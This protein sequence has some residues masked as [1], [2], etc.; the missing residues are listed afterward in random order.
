MLDLQYANLTHE[1][2]F[3]IL[4]ID[5]GPEAMNGIRSGL[6]ASETVGF[7]KINLFV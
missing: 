4:P 7:N 3:T 5:F 1:Q 2:T 6:S